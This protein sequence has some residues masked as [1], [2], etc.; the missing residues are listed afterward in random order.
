MDSFKD[1]VAVVTGGAGGIGR[2]LAERCLQ[3]GMKVVLAD[4]EEGALQRTAEELGTEGA[5][6]AVRTDVSKAEEV[7]ALAQK[8]LDRFGAVHLLFNNAGVG[9]GGSPWDSTLADWEWV[10]GVN[11][12]GVIHG[13]RSFVPRMLSQDTEGHVVNTASVA[14]LVPF[15]SCAAYSVTK[16]A[17]V[18]LSENANGFLRLQDAKIGVSVLCPGFVRTQIM[19]SGR[20]RPPELR[21]P[22]VE[23]SIGPADFAVGDQM[24]QKVE[25]GSPPAEIAG[26]VFRAIRERRFMILPHREFDPLIR[27]RVE[28]WLN[29]RAVIKAGWEWS[30]WR[31]LVT[32]LRPAMRTSDG[33]PAGTAD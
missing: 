4:I 12:W 17:V 8:T 30:G 5:V 27:E 19:D 1:K 16:Q 7:D 32:S 13:L 24:R 26:H 33:G 25:R 22:D 11:L 20:N 9:A 29:G 14:G 10:M 15:S 31:R 21:N 23:E 2:G 3:E 6:L 28:E 18:G